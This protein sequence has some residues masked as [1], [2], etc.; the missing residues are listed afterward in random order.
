MGLV[1]SAGLTVRAPINGQSDQ[2]STRRSVD[3]T[4]AESCLYDKI[5]VR[6]CR[7]RQSRDRRDGSTG[8]GFMM[9]E[10]RDERL[11]AMKTTERWVFATALLLAL[12]AT[13]ARL[14]A[15][16]KADIDAG[17]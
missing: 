6:P 12:A 3:R 13:P 1:E 11:R 8:C 7:P 17:K 5:L 14:W 10:R 9:R 15:Q 2:R 16:S 4:V